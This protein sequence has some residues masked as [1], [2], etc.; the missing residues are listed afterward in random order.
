MRKLRE[1]DRLLGEGVEL[2]DVTK[3]LEVSEARI[4]VGGRSMAG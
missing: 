2:S 4:T 3:R 1:A